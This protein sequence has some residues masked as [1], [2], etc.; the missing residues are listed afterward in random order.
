M[1]FDEFCDY[2]IILFQKLHLYVETHSHNQMIFPSGMI[3]YHFGMNF[4][5]SIGLFW[6]VKVENGV[7]YHLPLNNDDQ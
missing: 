7:N 5:S 6:K 4:L 1:V 2:R 3:E